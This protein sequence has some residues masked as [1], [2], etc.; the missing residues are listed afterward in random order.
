[1]I[2]GL[3]VVPDFLSENEQEEIVRNLKD[4]QAYQSRTGIWRYGENVYGSGKIESTIPDFLLIPA[5]KIVVEGHL[6]E[7]PR[8]VTV[9]QYEVG[10]SISPH[11]DNEKSGEIITVLSLLSDTTIYF[12]RHRKLR[13]PVELPRGSLMQMRGPARWQYK[14]GIPKIEHLRYSVVYRK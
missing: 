7:M 9:N 8:H 10:D 14:H 11:I 6:E 12:E 3:K 4:P 13:I 5:M 2:E 1:M